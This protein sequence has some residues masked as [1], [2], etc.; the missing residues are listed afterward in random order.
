MNLPARVQHRSAVNVGLHEDIQAI[1]FD[2]GSTLIDP[3]PSI[4]HLYAEVAAQHGHPNLCPDLLN[5]RFRA[6]FR[7]RSHPLHASAD[8]ELV[9]DQTFQGLVEPAPSRSFF[10]KLYRRFAQPSAWH[11]HADVIPALTELQ[12][13][14]L[15]LLVISNWDE[16]LRPLLRALDLDRFFQHIIVSCEIG[17]PK[18]HPVIFQHAVRCLRLPPASILHVGDHPHEDV[19][20]ARAAGFQALLIDRHHPPSPGAQVSALTQLLQASA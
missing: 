2:V 6:A 3:H 7:N 4:G 5:H 12:A 14:H 9:V 19:Y 16:R 18:P 20:G 8:W 13:R 11:V 15:P 1:T 17:Q 10:P